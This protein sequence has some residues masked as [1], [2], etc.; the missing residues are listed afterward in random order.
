VIRLRLQGLLLGLLLPL[1]ALAEPPVQ[2]QQL[3]PKQ[4][5]TQAPSAPIWQP[6]FTEPLKPPTAGVN[7]QPVVEAQNSAS[8]EPSYQAQPPVSWRPLQP[9][10]P[11]MPPLA[12]VDPKLAEQSIPLPQAP[13]L[14]SFNRSVAFTDGV[15]G[16]DIGF[17][18]PPGFRWSDQHFVDASVRG[19]NRRPPGSDFWAW[20]NGDA[21]GQ[22][23]VRAFQQGRWS[24]GLNFGFRS[25]YQGSQFGG[26]STQIGE[27]FSSG[28]RLDYA[29]SDT[30]GI[31]FGAEQL[32]HYD[33]NTDTGRD[34]YLVASKA[35]W[36]GGRQGDFPLLTGTAG[37]G[38]GYFG[39]LSDV[40]FACANTP[41][42]AGVSVD[43][44]Y[45]LC[46]GPIASAAVVFNPSFALFT[47]YNNYAWMAG[48]SIAPVLTLPLRMTW[49]VTLAESFDDYTIDSSQ[50]RWF[51]RLSLGF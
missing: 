7:W 20:N 34:I 46:W 4:S 15:V 41:G 29:L 16:P 10:E 32:I 17:L 31:A 22:L 18:V 6:V 51:F 30:A 40:K 11:E 12:P 43:T 13:A 1:P 3:E 5:S 37:V 19:W 49:G 48:A 38:T 25:I 44:Y 26:G 14:R 35:W 24:F 50:F 45:P 47:E 39:T 27:G 23:F 28:F 33:S 21:V 9:G 8:G 42:G 2:W 36:L